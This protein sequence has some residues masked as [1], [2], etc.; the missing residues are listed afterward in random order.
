MKN[1]K[2]PNPRGQ[3]QFFQSCPVRMIMFAGV[4]VIGLLMT[5]ASVGAV[6]P[7]ALTVWNKKGV[8]RRI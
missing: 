6:V 5:V 8:K 1:T 3:N 7:Q 2:Q 4:W